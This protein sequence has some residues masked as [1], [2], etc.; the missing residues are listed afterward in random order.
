M[1]G[2]LL[3]SITPTCVLALTLVFASLIGATTDLTRALAKHCLHLLSGNKSRLRQLHLERH[4]FA[5][6]RRAVPKEDSVR[7]G[8]HRILYMNGIKLLPLQPFPISSGAASQWSNRRLP[9][10]F[11][12]IKW[13]RRLIKAYLCPATGN[14]SPEVSPASRT[15][16]TPPSSTTATTDSFTTSMSIPIP[17]GFPSNGF[18]Q[19]KQWMVEGGF[20]DYK[21]Q[22]RY[23]MGVGSFQRDRDKPGIA[24]KSTAH[25]DSV[26]V[27][28]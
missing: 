18:C 8:S 25:S 3:T 6:E 23:Q 26:M 19:W 20:N 17:S 15:F 10:P 9:T 7:N 14:L 1:A 2:F 21:N 12:F 22:G 28:H 27:V 13:S 16:P 5:L 24:V 11:S 4:L